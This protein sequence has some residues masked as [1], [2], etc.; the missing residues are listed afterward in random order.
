MSTFKG[1]INSVAQ[2]D[3]ERTINNQ[4]I[5]E[6]LAGSVQA[7]RPCVVENI[8]NPNVVIVANNAFKDTHS[9][10]LDCILRQSRTSGDNFI[11]DI[12]SKLSGVSHGRQLAK[13]ALFYMDN[14]GI[15]S[16]CGYSLFLAILKA[17]GVS[18][19]KL[20]PNVI[21]ISDR[22]ATGG[23][24]LKSIQSDKTPLTWSEFPDA[25]RKGLKVITIE[26]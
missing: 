16:I 26:I 4:T 11:W 9:F 8:G 25:Q 18:P 24:A 21:E 3:D 10:F 17:F 2:I 6:Q 7:I 20:L 5:D 15:S 13:D 1:Y 19:M 22:K 23:S 12:T 14:I